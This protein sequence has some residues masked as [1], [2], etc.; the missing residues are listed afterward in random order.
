MTTFVKR[1]ELLRSGN[2]TNKRGRVDTTIEELDLET[3]DEERF[4][5]SHHRCGP[6]KR[7]CSLNH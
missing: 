1:V 7:Y 3:P 6:A 5:G 4:A 2:I